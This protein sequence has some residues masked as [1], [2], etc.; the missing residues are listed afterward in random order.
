MGFR[1]FATALMFFMLS[2]PAWAAKQR[3]RVVPVT[4]LGYVGDNLEISVQK[5]CGSEFVGLVTAPAKKGRL[6]IA[7]AVRTGDVMC[8]SM[9]EQERHLINYLATR[10][11]KVIA[12]LDV[13]KWR[14]R[15]VI[16]TI[17]DLRLFDKQKKGEGEETEM[18]KALQGV[19]HTKCGQH[20]GTLIRQMDKQK[21]EVAFVEHLVRGSRTSDCPREQKVRRI[22]AIK[23]TT[24][25]KVATYR[26]NKT[27]PSQYKLRLAKIDRASFR[28]M[29][30]GGVSFQ[31]LRNC[32]EA[33][34]G[35]VVG[36]RSL[37]KKRSGGARVRRQAVGMLV[38]HYPGL[39][40]SAQEAAEAWTPYRTKDVSI[41][42]NWQVRLMSQTKSTD[43]LKLKSP[44]EMAK[45]SKQKKKG[46][47][48]DFIR[49]CDL[50]VG[51]V[52]ARSL[53]AASESVLAVGVLSRKAGVQCKKRVT[54][55]SLFQPFVS[56]DVQVTDMFPLRIR[57]GA[58]SS[59]S[60][61]AH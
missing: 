16:S 25:L 37:A 18:A 58:A 30:K 15:F 60:A 45:L 59:R 11:F 33:P 49:G 55:A 3:L 53:W 32:N 8:M 26:E 27:S 43:S 57:G 10:D 50:T 40:C 4:L 36:K 2:T 35:I 19:H 34:I 12:P 6:H 9:P 52:Y 44:L 13:S 7:A 5:P 21:L 23:L 47:F 22:K 46:L 39:K 20:V 14:G 54:Q 41:P 17:S 38:A 31:Y 1:A 51:A 48:V 61:T 28:R 24:G 56:R 29:E 42:R